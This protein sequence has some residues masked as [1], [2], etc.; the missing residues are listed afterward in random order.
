VARERRSLVA[1]E[2]KKKILDRIYWIYRISLK[3]RRTDSEVLRGSLPFLENEFSRTV[4][5]PRIPAGSTCRPVSKKPV[6]ILF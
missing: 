3:E 1:G 2:N 6:R 4:S 5:K